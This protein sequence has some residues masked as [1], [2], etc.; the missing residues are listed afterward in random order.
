[1][2]TSVAIG[3]HFFLHLNYFCW[4]QFCRSPDLDAHNNRSSVFCLAFQ[5]EIVQLGLIA[6]SMR[7]F[8]LFSLFLFSQHLSLFSYTWLY[9]MSINTS[10]FT[11]TLT[12]GFVRVGGY[13]YLTYSYMRAVPNTTFNNPDTHC[14]YPPDDSLH[15]FRAIDDPDY[16]WTGVIFGLTISSVW[17]WCSDQVYFSICLHL[18]LFRRWLQLWDSLD[19][20]VLFLKPSQCNLI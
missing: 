16:P 5:W 12:V 17:Y 10:S 3:L 4:Q 15:F 9:C 7:A 1:M 11:N 13:E 18:V 14:G 8:L 19:W 2:I 6:L 20:F